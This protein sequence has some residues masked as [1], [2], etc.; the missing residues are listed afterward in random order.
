M[1]PRKSYSPSESELSDLPRDLQEDLHSRAERIKTA[2]RRNLTDVGRELL[3]AKAVL[4]HGQFATWLA[5]A[6]GMTPRTAQNIM[7]A[8]RLLRENE[9][10][11]HLG[12]SALYLLAGSNVPAAARAA[13]ARMADQGAVPSQREVKLLIS[14][15]EHPGPRLVNLVVQQ[16]HT[17][18][19]P[20][21]IKLDRGP[22]I[23]GESVNRNDA[24]SG[25]EIGFRRNAVIAEFA[26][27]LTKALN[28]QQLNRLVTMCRG[29]PL[30]TLAE[31]ADA[32]ELV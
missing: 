14:R 8:C 26:A 2:L 25:R 19:E 13:V 7:A 29:A 32:L 20:Q 1:P 12:R 30:G 23:T 18:H 6:V 21:I 24:Q 9:N 4:R 15:A 3:A 28:T 10:F 5:D 17:G 22:M 31:L 27:E 16:T 11:A